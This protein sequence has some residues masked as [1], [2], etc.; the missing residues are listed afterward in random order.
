M[1]SIP[2]GHFSYYAA[3]ADVPF[4]PVCFSCAQPAAAAATTFVAAIAFL[5]GMAF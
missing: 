1:N 4:Y 2:Y 3:F 5:M